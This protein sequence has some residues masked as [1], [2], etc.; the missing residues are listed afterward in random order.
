VVTA[1]Q[2]AFTGAHALLGEYASRVVMHLYE[3]SAAGIMDK[4]VT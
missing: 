3:I 1:E 2:A 4:N